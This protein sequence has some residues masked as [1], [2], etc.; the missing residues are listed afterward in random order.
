MV[1]DSNKLKRA[2][3]TEIDKPA[4]GYLIPGFLRISNK[5]MSLLPTSAFYSVLC[6]LLLN[7]ILSNRVSALRSNRISAPSRYWCSVLDRELL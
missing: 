7:L 5:Y 6:H 2:H 1:D 4:S 3:G